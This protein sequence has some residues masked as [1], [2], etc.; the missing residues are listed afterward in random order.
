MAKIRC[1]AIVLGVLAAGR[2]GLGGAEPVALRERVPEKAGATRV[3][4]T[5]KAEGLFL[6]NTPTGEKEVKAAKPLTLKVETRLDFAERVVATDAA[7]QPRRAVRWVNQAAAAIN[8]EVRP[9]AAVVRPEVALLVA[10]RREGDVVVASPSGPLT[11]PELDLLD[12]VGDPLLLGALLPDKPVVAG[13]RWRIGNDGA[14]GLSGYDVLATNSVDA[15]LEALDDA[16]AQVKFAG[17]IRGASYGGGEGTVQAAGSFT[18]D[19]KAERI[20]ELKLT[21]NEVRKPGEVEDG[22]DVKS[23]LTLERN[24]VETPAALADGVLKEVPEE[25]TPERLLLVH[26]SPDGKYSVRHDRDWHIYHETLRQSVLKRLDR[27]EVVAYCNLTTGPNAGKGR[28]QDLRQFR[29]GVRRAIGEG[30]GQF[31]G[32]G[33]VEGDPAGGFRYKVAVQ[34]RKGNLGVIWDYFLAAAPNGDQ[35]GIV[36]TLAEASAKAFG[37]Q[38]VQL[39]GSLRWKEETPKP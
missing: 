34:G 27:G 24:D 7:G 36:F 14:R 18:F 20:R 9:S 13:D 32:E 8:G 4:V 21:R 12:D 17:T 33:E 22:L 2:A 6:P 37:D 1:C 23:T 35:L 26:L 3:V 28:H 29:D 10:E 38:D 19:R 16:K 39:V 15:T 31:L 30:F 11:R 5:L 25:I